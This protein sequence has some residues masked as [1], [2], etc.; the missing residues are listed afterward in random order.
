MQ[1]GA[2]DEEQRTKRG[3]GFLSNTD[4]LAEGPA[5]E[6][7]EIGAGGLAT[8]APVV[9]DVV[10]GTERKFVGRTGGLRGR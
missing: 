4:G 5:A 7:R 2:R 1:V 9:V 3:V 10:A 6:E 8:V